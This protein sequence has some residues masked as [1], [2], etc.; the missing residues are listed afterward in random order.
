MF[1]REDRAPA[2]LDVHIRTQLVAAADAYA[3]SIDLDARLQAIVAADDDKNR[4]GTTALC[5]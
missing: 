1:D 5:L 4:D 2:G 3:S